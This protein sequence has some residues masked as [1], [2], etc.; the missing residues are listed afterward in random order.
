M[1]RFGDSTNL[2]ELLKLQQ[3][4]G[5]ILSIK[6]QIYYSCGILGSNDGVHTSRHNLHAAKNSD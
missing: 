6:M 1:C 4:G 5:E 3:N 2:I